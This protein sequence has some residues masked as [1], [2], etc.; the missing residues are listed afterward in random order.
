MNAIGLD[1]SE[2]LPPVTGSWLRR[3]VAHTRQALTSQELKDQL[4]K[5]ERAVQTPVLL[6]PQAEIDGQVGCAVAQL[7]TAL[8]SEKNAIIQARSIL[9]IKVNGDITVRNLTRSRWPTWNAS[10]RC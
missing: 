7:I 10:P 9:L 2:Q 8:T 5:I 4:A 1:I 3:G 6:K